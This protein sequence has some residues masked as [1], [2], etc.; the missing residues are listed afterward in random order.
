MRLVLA[1]PLLCMATSPAWADGVHVS[2][3]PDTVAAA[4]GDT[5]YLE[6]DVTEAGAPFNAFD[7]VIGFEPWRSPSCR[8]LRSRCRKAR[9]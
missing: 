6:L 2:L 1:I 9:S 4:A 8:P 5:L 7:T 3:L